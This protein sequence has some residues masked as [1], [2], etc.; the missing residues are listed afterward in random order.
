MYKC[1][2]RHAMKSNVIARKKFFQHR[3]NFIV[4][5]YICLKKE[6]YK[7]HTKNSTLFEGLKFQ[8]V[9]SLFSKFNRG[10]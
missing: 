6:Q 9:Q 2:L 5:L 3:G 1:T 8:T 7:F 10:R 4:Y